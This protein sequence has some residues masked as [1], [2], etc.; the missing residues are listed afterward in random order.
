MDWIY[1]VPEY[2]LVDGPSKHG[3]EPLGSINYWEVLE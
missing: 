3:N 1:L 2:G